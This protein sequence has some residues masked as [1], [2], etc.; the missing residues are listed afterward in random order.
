MADTTVTN[1]LFE[2][3]ARIVY[4]FFHNGGPNTPRMIIPQ[5]LADSKHMVFI[6]E[7][8]GFRQLHVLD[9]VYEQLRVWQDLDQDGDNTRMATVSGQLVRVQRHE[10]G[11]RRGRLALGHLRVVAGQAVGEPV[12]GRVGEVVLQGVE[13][14]LLLDRLAHRVQVERLVDRR[15]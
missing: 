13:D 2:D 10:P 8:S 15:P 5:Y 12:E 1:L 3:G 6:T 14:E 11:Q 9:P 7:V 4:R